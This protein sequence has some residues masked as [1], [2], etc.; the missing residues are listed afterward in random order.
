MHFDW[1]LQFGVD[2]NSKGYIQPMPVEF[3]VNGTTPGLDLT[4]SFG[5][6]DIEVKD[7]PTDPSHLE[8]HYNVAINPEA[9]GITL[10]ATQSLS[11]D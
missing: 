6:A 7:D 9:G 4:G 10:N 2:K 3:N 11:A 5:Q 8:G 1:E